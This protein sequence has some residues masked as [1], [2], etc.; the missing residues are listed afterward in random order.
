ML[1]IFAVIFAVILTMVLGMIFS[2]IFAMVFTNIS[3][4][5][6]GMFVDG[7]WSFRLLAFAWRPG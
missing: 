1:V 4:L 3:F 2:M 7:W 5:G 6:P